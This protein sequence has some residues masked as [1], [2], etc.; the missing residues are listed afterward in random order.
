VS[1]DIS[2]L[3]RILTVEVGAREPVPCTRGAVRRAIGCW[4][5]RCTELIRARRAG[6]PQKERREKAAPLGRPVRRNCVSGRFVG[7]VDTLGRG[8]MSDCLRAKRKR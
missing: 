3:S 8:S 6:E 1:E 2:I 7:P 4:R 5:H